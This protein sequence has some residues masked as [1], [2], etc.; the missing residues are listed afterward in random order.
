MSDKTIGL[1]FVFVVAGVML[2]AGFFL[3]RAGGL[4]KP[5]ISNVTPTV[6]PDN[7]PTGLIS[8]TI[9]PIP[10]ATPLPT[11]A[12]TSTPMP[13]STPVP[14]NTPVPPTNTPMSSV[15]P[16][17][18]PQADLYI[19]EYAFNHPPKQGEPFTVRI[20]IYNQGNSATGPFWWE[21]WPTAYGKACRERIS[22]GI[23]AHGGRIVYC[24]YT[25]GGWSTYVT[26]AV[27]DSD[28][29]VAESNETNNTYTQTVIPI[30]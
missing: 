18:A 22:D 25:Y 20:G 1:I 26:K 4:F 29:E 11:A 23:A 9:S 15:T 30:H 21:W 2:G 8:P 7:S 28:N 14:T 27:A 19:S 10:T 13:T 5:T 24:A 17:T 16:T 3:G 12:P 6:I